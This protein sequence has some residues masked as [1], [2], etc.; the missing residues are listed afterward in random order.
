MPSSMPR[1]S[2]SA[3]G[4]MTRGHRFHAK[5]PIALR[6]PGGYLAALEKGHVRADFEARRA[7]IR[8][9]RRRRGHGRGRRGR[10]RPR[11][12]RRGDRAH[13]MAGAARGRLRAAF[14][15]APA[16]GP[17]RDDAGPPALLS[18]ARPGREA[19]AALHRGRQP[20][21]QGSRRRCGPATSASCARASRTPPSSMRPDRKATLQS[22]RAALGAV[23]VPGPARLACRQDGPRHGPRRPDRAGRRPGSRDRAACRGDLPSA[24]S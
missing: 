6:S 7:R 15:R 16:R 18:G 17:R 5:K 9:G 13:R 2:A 3:R 1:S 10:H 20:R 23:D 21:E 22:R 4:R 19:D 11:G 8:A 24:T 14:P 12:A